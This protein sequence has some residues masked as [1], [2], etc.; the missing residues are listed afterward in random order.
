MLYDYLLTWIILSSLVPGIMIFFLPE[1][2]VRTRSVLNIFGSLVKMSLVI[3]LLVQVYQG[4]NIYQSYELLPGIQIEL[5]SDLF[6][7]ILAVLSSILWFFTTFYAIGYLEHHHSRS[8]FFG[9]FS[10]V[11]TA[12]MG[13]SFAGNLFTFLLFF[14]MLT[15]VTY[16]LVVHNGTQE[17]RKGGQVYI[18]YTSLGGVLFLTGTV[19]MY[20]LA[21]N[22]TFAAGGFVAED[23][24]N[25]PMEYS[26]IFIMLICGLGVKGALFPLHGWLPRAMVAPAPVSALLHAVAVVKAGAFGIV[27]VVYDVFGVE[28][29]QAHGLLEILLYMASFTVVYGSVMA[30][31][32]DNL[33]KRLAYSTVSQVSYIMLGV[34][35]FG[36]LGTIGGVI[37]LVNQGIMKITLFFCAGSFAETYG[38]KYVSKMDGIGK[39]MPLTM[40]AFTIGAFG[41]MGVPP[42][43][44]FISK[45]YLGMGA[46]ESGMTWVIGVLIAS[47]LLNAAYF[48][49]ILYRGWFGTFDASISKKLD[50]PHE[51]LRLIL[52]PTVSVAVISLL[53]GLF[54][55]LDYSPLYFA[56]IIGMLEYGAP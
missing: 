18:A 3:V 9:F 5:V 48:L 1:K 10:L 42:I 16:P 15:I 37:H 30:L 31:F 35:L 46:V 4:A 20:V 13:I 23:F 43:A 41:M 27:R 44:G 33:K 39:K 51:T 53:A 38:I 54:A 2:S 34:A 47:T 56:K 29:A 50:T 25:H 24:A 55:S 49:P 11:V 14:E 6:S 36:P 28:T 32:Q 21:G 19:W 17:A 12:T 45:W 8:R 7:L 52:W 40:L 22:Q 26:I